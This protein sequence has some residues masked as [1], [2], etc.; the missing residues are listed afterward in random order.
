MTFLTSTPRTTC[1]LGLLLLSSA[2]TGTPEDALRAKEALVRYQMTQFSSTGDDP[3]GTFC[4]EYSDVFDRSN[5]TKANPPAELIERLN[6]GPRR[7]R[8]G[9][10]CYFKETSVLEKGSG[11]PAAWLI[12]GTIFWKSK[13]SITITGGYFSGN[14]GASGNVYHLEKR[15]GRWVVTK[16]ELKWI[17]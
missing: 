11:S 4:V 1:V 2:C 6:E 12:V 13:T 15:D 3:V 9:S 14:E 7:V 5:R 10:D 8:N 17:S 16:N